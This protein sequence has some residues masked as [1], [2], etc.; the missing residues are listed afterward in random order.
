MA[1]ADGSGNY[2]LGDRTRVDY[3]L[4]RRGWLI[5]FLID[6]RCGIKNNTIA[7][8]KGTL[9]KKILRYANGQKQAEGM[10][11]KTFFG[12][13]IEQGLWTY[14]QETVRKWPKG[15]L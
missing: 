5:G 11:R 6:V 4:P 14:W 8:S 3:E 2:T 1:N 13:E 7:M 12:P 15:Y 9:N 10:I